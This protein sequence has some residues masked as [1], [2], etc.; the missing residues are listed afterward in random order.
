MF[1]CDHIYFEENTSKKLSN[2]EIKWYVLS[3]K[4]QYALSFCRNDENYTIIC[5]E[6][7]KD[8]YLN[9]KE[10]IRNTCQKGKTHISSGLCTA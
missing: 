9:S 2:F 6:C 5:Y 7:L 1:L 3:E 4:F 8:G 10:R